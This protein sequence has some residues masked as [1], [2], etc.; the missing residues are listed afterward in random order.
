M[1]P[2]LLLT[3]LEPPTPAT[4]GPAPNELGTNGTDVRAAMRR[5]ER[6]TA[7]MSK[8]DEDEDEDGT[9]TARPPPDDDDGSNV[10]GDETAPTPDSVSTPETESDE[11]RGVADNDDAEADADAEA[12]GALG[13]RTPTGASTPEL[14]EAEAE[15][16]AALSAATAARRGDAP[17][18]GEGTLAA[19]RAPAER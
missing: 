2:T 7:V 8:D 10:G 1:L 6:E 15:A 16:A 17:T 14:A 4:Q 12:A 19:E 9:T 11:R 13:G 18:A 3:P 5:G